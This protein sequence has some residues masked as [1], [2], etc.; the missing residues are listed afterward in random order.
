MAGDGDMRLTIPANTTGQSRRA[1][2]VLDGKP[3]T[4][5]QAAK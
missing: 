3:L 1:A 2:F 4:I 5:T